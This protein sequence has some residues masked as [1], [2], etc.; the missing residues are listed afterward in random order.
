MPVPT[1]D[2][3]ISPVLRYLAAHADGAAITDT[4]EAVA[5]AMKLTPRTAR[6]CCRAAQ[7]VFKIGWVNAAL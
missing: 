5:N 7:A 4:Y 3:F 1:Y 6:R 2:Q